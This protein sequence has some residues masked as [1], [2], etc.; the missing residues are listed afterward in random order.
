[1]YTGILKQHEVTMEIG[2]PVALTKLSK[3]L[4]NGGRV[5]FG[6]IWAVHGQTKKRRHEI[7]TAIDGDSLNIHEVCDREAQ[8]TSHC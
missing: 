3:P 2:E 6:S 1:M 7:C 5:H 4:Q 8:I